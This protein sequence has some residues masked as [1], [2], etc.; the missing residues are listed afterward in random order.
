MNDKKMTRKE[1]LV[2]FEEVDFRIAKKGEW[3]LC[4]DNHSNFS[5]HKCSANMKRLSSVI[6][7][8]A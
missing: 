6:L 1:A 5:T 8:K 2:G 4:C 3:I 7:K